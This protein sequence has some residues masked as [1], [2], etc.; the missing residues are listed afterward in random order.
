MIDAYPH[1]AAATVVASINAVSL[2]PAITRNSMHLSERSH[3]VAPLLVIW[4]H[5]PFRHA[6]VGNACCLGEMLLVVGAICRNFVVRHNEYEGVAS[7]FG[8]AGIVDVEA[9]T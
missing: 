9:V 6:R 7:P 2:A 5:D 4:D 1:M 8:L 3:E